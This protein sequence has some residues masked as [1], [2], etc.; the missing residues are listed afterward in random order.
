MGGSEALDD[1]LQFFMAGAAAVAIGSA[2]FSDPLTILRL[3]GELKNY[4]QRM[5]LPS[6][7]GIIG[8]AHG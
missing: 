1:A 8:V 2:S 4:L 7:E 5:N 3:T 6:L